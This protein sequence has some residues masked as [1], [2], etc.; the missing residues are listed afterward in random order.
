MIYK[1]EAVVVSSGQEAS[2]EMLPSPIIPNCQ[3]LDTACCK[4]V[5]SVETTHSKAQ[6]SASDVYN[7]KSR[8]YNILLWLI[9]G[10]IHSEGIAPIREALQTVMVAYPE[11]KLEIRLHSI[12][13]FAEESAII[14]L[15][16]SVSQRIE[17][18]SLNRVQLN[19]NLIQSLLAGLGNM[20]TLD[21]SY[22]ELDTTSVPALC[23]L[24]N[25][26]DNVLPG[27]KYLCLSGLGLCD[28]EVKNL[29]KV[30]QGCPLGTVDLSNNKI[31]DEGAYA[32]FQN[33]DLRVGRVNL[34]G[35]YILRPD[36][37]YGEVLGGTN[38]NNGL[39]HQRVPPFKFSP[40]I[41]ALVVATRK[42]VTFPEEL[43]RWFSE[44][45]G[46]I[47]L[48]EFYDRLLGKGSGDMDDDLVDPEK[49]SSKRQCTSKNDS[50][51]GT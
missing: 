4:W 39:R 45:V 3:A 49:R 20:D 50:V 16:Q 23:A 35:N 10:R 8:R 34:R 19:G 41:V 21:M 15:I 6:A 13:H 2:H 12:P 38:P 18:L 11:S 28:A 1:Q 44:E 51:S 5:K 42:S 30:I 29:T 36:V 43:L 25:S 24:L 22:C 46:N 26:P 48:N 37:L 7:S 32:V 9:G 27:I 31:S 33:V 14:E 47:A 40:K 17:Y